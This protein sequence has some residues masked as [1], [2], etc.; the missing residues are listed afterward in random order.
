MNKVAG[1][2][3]RRTKSLNL[4]GGPGM[5]ERMGVGTFE[6]ESPEQKGIGFCGPDI[7]P[8]VI[9]AHREPDPCA[10]HKLR[11][12]ATFVLKLG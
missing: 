9:H 8:L 7:T 1:S 6:S 3:G 11:L 4:P 2:G 5:R 10:Q 12:N